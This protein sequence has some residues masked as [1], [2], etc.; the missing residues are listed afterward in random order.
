[1]RREQERRKKA[2]KWKEGWKEGCEKR[3]GQK[4]GGWKEWEEEEQRKGEGVYYA[5]CVLLLKAFLRLGRFS[6][7]HFLFPPSLFSSS[8]VSEMLIS[9]PK[10]PWNIERNRKV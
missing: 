5:Y 7:Y 10:I 1:V 3:G 9:P 6:S 8:C 4:G 2:G